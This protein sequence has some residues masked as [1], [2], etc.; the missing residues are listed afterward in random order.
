[1]YKDKTKQKE[2][3]REAARRQRQKKGMTQGMT[4]E[5]GMTQAVTSKG[6]TETKGMT[7]VPDIIDKLTSPFWRD[8]L[9]RWQRA[10]KESHHPDYAHDVWLGDVTLARAFDLLDCTR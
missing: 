6:M 8:R 3:N 10:F 7:D 9:A 5:Q 1:M 2:A 4:V